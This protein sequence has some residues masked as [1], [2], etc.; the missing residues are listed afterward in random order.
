MYFDLAT[1]AALGQ[2]KKRSDVQYLMVRES[3]L[4]P[5]IST[6]NDLAVESRA[7]LTA[8]VEQLS[9]VASTAQVSTLSVGA[10]AGIAVAGAAMIISIAV[11]GVFVARKKRNQ[12]K[13]TTKSSGL[14]MTA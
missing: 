13:T 4:G 1:A 14:F 7:G 5:G 8:P 10:I 12:K 2:L 9:G 6:A 11:I 3:L